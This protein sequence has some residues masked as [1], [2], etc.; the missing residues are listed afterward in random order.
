MRNLGNT[1]IGMIL[2]LINSVS[3]TLPVVMIAFF[4]AI[5]SAV[6]VQISWGIY[7]LLT[8]MLF[9]PLVILRKN[10]NSFEK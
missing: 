1:Q 9:I 4:G 7:A 10:I 6:G 8:I 2:G 5:S 3:L